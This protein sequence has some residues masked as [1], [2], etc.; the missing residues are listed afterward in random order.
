MFALLAKQRYI[1]SFFI[2]IYQLRMTFGII[3]IVNLLPGCVVLLIDEHIRRAR[4]G[5]LQTVT[6]AVV[7]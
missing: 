3:L 7:Y 6:V 4:L 2:D 5:R 1:P